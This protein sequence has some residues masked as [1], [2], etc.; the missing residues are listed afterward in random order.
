MERIA[1]NLERNVRTQM[2][3]GRAHIVAPV[4]LLVEG[5]HTGMSGIPLYYSPDALRETVYFWDG[6][7]VTVNHP[8]NEQG[9]AVSANRPDVLEA[10]RVGQLFN[11]WFDEN[12]NKLKGELWI[13][14]EK[15]RQL[16]PDSLRLI[17]SEQPL[18]VSTGFYHETEFTSGDWNGEHYEASIFNFRPDHLA[19]LPED[20]GACSWDDGCGVR[21][22]K[23]QKGDMRVSGNTQQNGGAMEKLKVIAKQF[24][25]L[26]GYT[27]QEASHED[28]R[29][30]LQAQLDAMD[31]VGWVHFVRDI[32]DDY[33]IYEARYR[34]DNPS[35]ESVSGAQKFY[36]RGYNVA[37]DEQ[38]TM[39]DD[40]AEVRE[41]REWVAMSAKPDKKADDNHKPTH[42]EESNMDRKEVI[43]G[44]I[45]N[46]KNKFCDKDR[47]WL[48]SLKEEQLGKIAP[49]ANQEP[50]KKPEEEPVK[51][52]E[53]TPA[54]PPEPK[55]PEPKPEGNEQPVTVDEYVSKAPPEVASFLKRAV[56]AENE[57]KDVLVKELVA[58]K[59]CKFT[60]EQLKAKDVTE[61]EQLAE[62]ANVEVDFTGRVGAPATAGEESMTMPPVFEKVK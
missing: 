16:S 10:I 42:E 29:G 61:L 52:P 6:I 49:C 35:D 48:D 60:E 45:A 44:L 3:D 57:K 56:A 54:D 62:L 9:E 28:I 23:K 26:F 47:E 17:Q 8:Q 37:E 38:A 24:A 19:L 58:N 4:I 14:A 21:A 2:F 27:V 5:V 50:E 32:Y 31:N 22:N 39:K 40:T 1:A 20:V 25:T 33:F 59:R 43:D 13:D 36:R 12:G 46:E 51:P 15:T 30:Q 55:P 34:G 53:P 11:V 41:V 18:E 7:P